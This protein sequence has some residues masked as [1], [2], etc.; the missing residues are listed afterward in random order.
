MILLVT[1]SL[2]VS[3]VYSMLAGDAFYTRVYQHRSAMQ[4]AGLPESEGELITHL[5]IIT[6]HT[7]DQEIPGERITGSEDDIRQYTLSEDG[8]TRIVVDFTMYSSG[9]ANK[10]SDTPALSSRAR[11]RYRGNYSRWFYKKSYSVSLVMPDGISQNPRSLAGLPAH[12]EWV[13][14]GPW[15]DRT[16]LRNYLAYNIAGEIMDYAPNVRF[17]EMFLDDEYHGVYLLV[18]PVT[19][20][21][22]RLDLIPNF[23]FY[24]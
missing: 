5:P 8:D 19:R 24:T 4:P 13:L 7:N 23:Q 9:A 15:I 6:L 3:A 21:Q 20:A 17:V 16:L 11:I 1:L 22:G 10:L 12:D 2:A 18:E 14:H